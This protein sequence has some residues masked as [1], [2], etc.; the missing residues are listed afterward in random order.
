MYYIKDITS[1][2]SYQ[3]E[4]DPWDDVESPNL[5]FHPTNQSSRSTTR[6]R[7]TDVLLAYML[8]ENDTQ[9][10]SQTPPINVKDSHLLNTMKN[11]R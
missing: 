8:K 7:A 11:P 2:P 6:S 9:I 3:L 1:S 5:Q 4:E 10:T